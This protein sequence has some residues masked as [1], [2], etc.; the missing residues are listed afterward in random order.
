MVA[1]GEINAKRRLNK[2]KKKRSHD[3]MQEKFQWVILQ[4]NYFYL[5]Y[6]KQTPLQPYYV[7]I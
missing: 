1:D 3:N 6:L 5:H 4:N 7:G 2:R